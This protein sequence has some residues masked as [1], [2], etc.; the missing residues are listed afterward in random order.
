M[1]QCAWCDTKKAPE[2]Y[3]IGEHSVC[4]R[5]ILVATANPTLAFSSPP[6]SDANPKVLAFQEKSNALQLEEY[7]EWV[8]RCGNIPSF[9]MKSFL[10]SWTIST[11]IDDFLLAFPCDIKLGESGEKFRI[12]IENLKRCAQLF[13]PTRISRDKVDWEDIARLESFGISPIMVVVKVAEK[14]FGSLD[15]AILGSHFVE[16][17]KVCANCEITGDIKKTCPRC[18]EELYCSRK[19]QKLHWK[20]HKKGCAG[21]TR[22]IIA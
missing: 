3:G 8:R 11:L 2:Y 13:P 15:P 14:M 21:P 1:T 18:D 5:C 12:D 19:C 9:D 16:E 20:K 22:G 6:P 4:H 10:E 17:E 7:L